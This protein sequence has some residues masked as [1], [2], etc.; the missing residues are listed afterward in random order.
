MKIQY[1]T[2]DK[3]SLEEALK[4]AGKPSLIILMSPADKF[5]AN[6]EKL[7]QLYPGVP[8]IG[9]IAMGY[10]R[11]VA[12]KGVSVAMFSDGITVK[13]N[14]L[15]NVSNMPARHIDRLEKDI[16]SIRPGRDNTVVIDLCSGNDAGV[17]TTISP[18]LQKHGIQLM[19]GTGDAGKVSANGKVYPDGMAYALIQNGRGKV[20]V[21]KEN[22]YT[23][24]EGVRLIASKTDR[25]NYYIGELN[26]RSAKQVYMDILG[27][28][29][30]QIGTQTFVNPFGKVIGDDICIISI[31]EVKGTGL[32]CYR[33][34]NDSDILTL[35]EARDFDEI[36]DQTIDRIHS[37]FSRISGIFSVNCAF[38]HLL[39]TDKGYMKPYLSKMGNLGSHC[40]VVGYGE[41]FNSQF[42]NQTM[43]CVVFE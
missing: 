34:V 22:I 4:G 36:V 1:G 20:K 25:S 17:L 39:F 10:G 16:E 30:S 42:V 3:G 29:E 8:S 32:C 12:Q 31:K 27:I 38:R 21:Y 35:L 26:G 19:G 23:P 5:E 18:V 24:M 33:Q 28:S 37:D 41:H 40:G 9:C 2:S 43:T 13:T 6:V 7:E 11:E 15:E 14:I